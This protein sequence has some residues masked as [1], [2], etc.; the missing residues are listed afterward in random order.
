MI[1]IIPTPRNIE[2]NSG[3]FQAKELSVYVDKRIIAA[4]QTLCSEFEALTCSYVPITSS[5]RENNAIVI[6]H[7]SSGEGYTLIVSETRIS[8]TA[9]GPAGAFYGIQTLRQL[10]KENG[11]FV[12]R[13]RIDDAPDFPYR[14]FYHDISRGRVC[15]LE[16]LKKIADMLSYFKMNSLQL[17]VED[18][19]TFKEL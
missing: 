10:L 17:Y 7:G 12:P 4:A 3:C 15:R 5:K 6:T 16:T 18:A 19:F 8:I 9:Q 1:H 13:C 11:L 14:G 2:E